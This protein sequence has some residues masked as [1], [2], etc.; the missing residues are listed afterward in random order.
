MH[1]IKYKKIEGF[2]KRH[3]DTVQPRENRLN[4]GRIKSRQ[5]IETVGKKKTNGGKSNRR[6]LRRNRHK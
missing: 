3:V 1:K 4:D 5:T 6:C 2:F